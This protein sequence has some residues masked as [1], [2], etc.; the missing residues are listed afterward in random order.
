MPDGLHHIDGHTVSGLFVGLIIALDGKDCVNAVIRPALQPQTLARSKAADAA[1]AQNTVAVLRGKGVHG[2][3]GLAS[4][5]N[6]AG[7]VG[8]DGIFDRADLN[9]TLA[10][11]S[12]ERVRN[13]LA[14]VPAPGVDGGIA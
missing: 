10:A 12:G 7:G 2:C 3:A 1:L 5:F 4:T 13:L 14:H 9:G 8:L 6:V 11:A